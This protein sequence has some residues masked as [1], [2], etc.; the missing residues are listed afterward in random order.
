MNLS[1]APSKV[2]KLPFAYRLVGAAGVSTLAALLV[3]SSMVHMSAQSAPVPGR[4][5]NVVGGP[6]FINLNPFEIMGDPNRS[7]NVEPD[8]DVDSRNPAVIVCSDVDYRLVDYAG[9]GG[10]SVHLDSWNGILQSRDGGTTWASRLHPGHP[11]DPTPGVLKK[12]EYAYDP[13]VRF[14]A[15]G[16]MYHVG[17]AATRDKRSGAI[18]S[19]TWVHLS[20]LEDDLEPVRLANNTTKEIA[21]T[22][23]GQFQDRPTL[24]VGDR[25]NGRTCTFEVPRRDGT[26][27]TQT[28]PCT[29]AY[30]A[31]ATFVGQRT[32]FFFTKTLNGGKGWTQPI[33]VSEMEGIGQFIQV[34]KVPNS[35]RLLMFWRRGASPPPTSQTDAIMMAR[36]DNDGDTWTKAAVFQQLCPFDQ[37]TSFTRFRFKSSPSAT[38]DA[39]GHVYV[40]WHERPR[41]A[42][43]QC[44]ARNPDG[45]LSDA[46]V[47]LS[48]TTDGV[49][50][51]PAI[52][53]DPNPARGHQI[54]P[55]VAATAG[56]V[57]IAWL[58]F[59][60]DASAR[61]EEGAD[62]ES[63]LKNDPFMDP[64]RR[65]TA[66]MFARQGTAPGGNQ[67]P[68]FGS[69]SVQISKYVFGIPTEAGEIRQQLQWNV[70][71]SRNFGGMLVPFDGDLNS[72][73]GE[74]IV[75][76]D[77]IGA[78]GAWV[79]NGT[80]GSPTRT[81]VYHTFWAD[82]RHVRLISNERY[83][84]AAGNPV[85]R[86]Y[87]PPDYTPQDIP[88]TAS[89]YDPTQP[90]PVCDPT[91]SFAGTKNLEIYTSRSTQG[92]Y[93]FLPWNNKAMIKSSG[94]PI[95]RVFV[96][97]VQNTIPS[98][99]N[100]QPSIPPTPYRLRIAAASPGTTASWKQFGAITPN[101]D[102]F[103]APGTAIAR[104]LYVFNPTNPRAAVK[105]VVEE[106][107]GIP[108]EVK[109]GGRTTTLFVNPDPAAPLNPLR[110]GNVDQTA[111]RFDITRFEVHDIEISRAQAQDINLPAVQNQ[112]PQD[113]VTGWPN[114]GWDAPRWENPR[115]EN[116]RWE[117]PRWENPRWENPRW[118]NEGWENGT[119]SD[120]DVNN[121]SYRQVRATYTNI[122]NTTSAYDVRVV[123][124][125]A[126]SRLRFQLIAYKLYTTAGQDACDHSLTGNTQVLVNIPNYD[127]S[128]SNLHSPPPESIQ[129]TTIHLHPGETVY[130]VLV[131]FDPTTRTFIDGRLPVNT[132]V[133]AARPQAVNTVD[134]D[135]GITEPPL[136]F[137]DSPFLTFTGQPTNAFT[138]AVIEASCGPVRVTAQDA[139]GALIPGMAVTISLGANPGG[140][141]LSGT[142]TRLTD[143]T[144]VATFDDLSINNA[145]T[146]YTLVA[147]AASA[148]SDTSDPFDITSAFLVTNTSDTG[149]GSLRQAMTDANT[150]PGLDV[151]AFN[152]PGSGPRIIAPASALPT[153][154]GPV[155]IDGLTQPGSS[156]NAPLI[157]LNGGNEAIGLG[158]SGLT[159]GGDGSLVQ[160][161]V[162][163]G[164]PGPG[165]TIASDGNTIRGNFIGVSADG[166][167]P[168]ANAQGISIGST[169]TL[170]VIGGDFSN[171]Q[172]IIG[173]NSEWGIGIEGS[174]NTVRGNV[175]GMTG[176]EFGIGAPNGTTG[177]GT[178]AGIMLLGGAA[179]NN[180]SGASDATA[181]NIIAF[182]NGKGVSLSPGGI[183][184]VGPAG[185]GNRIRFNS[186]DN[187]GGLG[188][189]INN[190]GIT[191]NDGGAPPDTDTGPNDVQNT[192]VL[193]GSAI[194]GGPGGP[195]TIS[196]TLSST[197][198][199]TFQ[200]DYYVSES[201]ST[202][203][204]T[205][206][207]GSTYFGSGAHVT[208]G[209]G[210]VAIGGFGTVPEV[211]TVGRFLTVTVTNPGGSTS[212][213]S[214]CVPINS[215]GPLPEPLQPAGAFT[216]E[217]QALSAGSESAGGVD[218]QR[219]PVG[220]LPTGEVGLEVRGGGIRHA[221][222][223]LCAREP[224]REGCGVAERGDVV[225]KERR[226]LPAALLARLQLG[227]RFG[228]APRLDVEDPEIEVTEPGVGQLLRRAKSLEGVD[229]FSLLLRDFTVNHL[230]VRTR[231]R[232]EL[233]S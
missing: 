73:R 191:A 56:F 187:N 218:G 67:N 170:N 134:A 129:N 26:I 216:P 203:S 91:E 181:P 88:N 71:F 4:N 193:S 183:A 169:A 90:R 120:A 163:N 10:G 21:F 40:A 119:I 104:S 149:A 45:T 206:R 135:A 111:E 228:R 18:Y 175:I 38:A 99:Q 166:V 123:V 151:I 61:F 78:P 92:L 36:S 230:A 97:A 173:G 179:N 89:L 98:P 155:Q 6:T 79:Y 222:P 29:T 47:F 85:P 94:D 25:P 177:F 199:T 204:V 5:T 51:T 186:I 74:S 182:N 159:V 126:D 76:R 214:N 208:D 49:N 207:D 37:E 95:Q 189:D 12:Y 233:L 122:G 146:G 229:R 161:L 165:M 132:V 192:A 64:R 58:D 65:H 108:G 125:G 190:D 60:N 143:A 178:S 15:A 154:T 162:I 176:L 27:A 184:G 46:R 70:L 110:P 100:G 54:W 133:F 167:T 131:A 43:G 124:N 156:S 28:V 19:S 33:F 195:L 215:P 77:P 121:G 11:L 140:G 150:H 53:V 137:A 96:V 72:N 66:D 223:L 117:N 224:V 80:P 17:G 168:N 23:P 197:P 113:E 145:G 87:A 200:V 211:V 48:T 232:L 210:S 93:A 105:V 41:D 157:V 69:P 213:F 217:P 35:Q 32:K 30:L 106:L 136:V 13:Q 68:T 148:G 116:P 147:S 128:A 209:T 102:V 226:G 16:V 198:G 212:E 174:N 138:G 196:G 50:K 101:E 231:L 153:L 63:V 160:G 84:D 42:Q 205:D 180:I 75:P 219:V 139:S 144:G 152:I 185:S 171:D 52:A 188:I 82:G 22:G 14:G 142:K 86:P 3:A 1:T 158:T 57:H 227:E 7:Q 103:I 220:V 2:R 127:T 221:E 107:T 59:R 62:E 55:T 20:D 130:T 39:G 202:L 34:V 201:C 164:W 81:P 112:G 194:L 114:T 31:Y 118:E 225:E 44:S 141:T 109:P 83:F 8:C 115:W 172:N 24:A 9:V